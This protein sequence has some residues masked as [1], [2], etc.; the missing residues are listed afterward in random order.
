MLKCTDTAPPPRAQT[1]LP[2]SKPRQL[3]LKL[4]RTQALQGLVS[5]PHTDAPRERKAEKLKQKFKF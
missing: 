4:N 3:I 5:S 2:E 1:E